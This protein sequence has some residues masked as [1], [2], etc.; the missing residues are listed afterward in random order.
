MKWA[1]YFYTET[2]VGS[3]RNKSEAD[4]TDIR[5]KLAK[6]LKNR[7]NQANGQ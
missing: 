1:Y 6:L 2:V 5:Y 7:C 3:F 4:K